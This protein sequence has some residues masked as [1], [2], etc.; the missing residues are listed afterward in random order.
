MTELSGTSKRAST[1]SNSAIFSALKNPRCSL[2]PVLDPDVPHFSR[3]F[4]LP[5]VPM[6]WR[7]QDFPE[8]GVPALGGAR[9][10]FLLKFPEN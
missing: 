4:G 7:I 8:E 10:T 9:M 5:R 2:G 1:P 3:R 6:Q